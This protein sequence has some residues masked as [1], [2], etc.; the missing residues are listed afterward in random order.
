[1][2]EATAV[3]IR[4]LSPADYAKKITEIRDKTAQVAGES[5]A[6]W[7][8]RRQAGFEELLGRQVRP[9]E[10]EYF[11]RAGFQAFTNL[12]KLAS[13]IQRRV[14]ASGVSDFTIQDARNLRDQ[15]YDPSQY[16]KDNSYQS[17]FSPQLNTGD[18]ALAIEN[19][20][21]TRYEN[22]VQDQIDKYTNPDVTDTSR[23][24]VTS[25]FQDLFGRAPTQ[26]ELD[27]YSQDIA[28]GVEGGGIDPLGL[29]EYLKT[30]SEYQT[31]QAAKDREAINQELLANEEDV[32]RKAQPQIIGSYMRAGRLNSSG[33]DSALSKARAE[34]ASERQNM[35]T[36][37]AR[38]D[39]VGARNTAF[40]NYLRN[41]DPAY[42]QR[43]AIQGAGNYANFQQPYQDLARQYSLADQARARQYE[44]A[45]YD[46]MQSDFMR[47]LDST[48]GSR[49][50]GALL[51]ALSG[52][53]ALSRFGP[54]G[55]LAGGALGAYAGY[56]NDR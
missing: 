43:F 1:M 53:G 16:N 18:L 11:G 17:D 23:Q 14:Q 55:A 3:D 24:D 7:E 32:F 4:S 20:G 12:E 41:S 42:Q 5:T 29:E 49:G 34:L 28:R 30:T 2:A 54:W 35:L 9:D 46:R 6:D 52:A 48:R 40:Q 13:D 19:V 27:H 50:G 25:V 26:R 56:E 47:Y 36:G 15:Y 51:G 39:V 44:V 22:Q 21:R 33:L 10:L 37:Y 31:A 38:E 8:K 45:D